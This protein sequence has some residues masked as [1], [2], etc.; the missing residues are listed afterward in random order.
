MTTD[1]FGAWN[2]NW[3]FLNCHFQ[4]FEFAG[5]CAPELLYE[6]QSGG[7]GQER[8]GPIL[9]SDRG[10]LIETT[11]DVSPEKII[12]QL[13]INFEFE[14]NSF[15]FS[16]KTLNAFTFHFFF[17]NKNQDLFYIVFKLID[18]SEQFCEKCFVFC[19]Q[20]RF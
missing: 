4:N 8:L 6:S 20:F 19:G 16:Y 1:F 10:L 2:F 12:G 5:A 15:Q 3:S 7:K 11:Q 18:Q 13:I 17:L 14:S 9:V